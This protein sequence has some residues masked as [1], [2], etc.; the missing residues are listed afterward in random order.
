[1]IKPVKALSTDKTLSQPPPLNRMRAPYSWAWWVRKAPHVQVDP[2][3]IRRYQD[4]HGVDGY[5]VERFMDS[6]DEARP[7]CELY[8]G[9]GPH[10]QSMWIPATDLV[11]MKSALT[12]LQCRLT[13]VA[14]QEI[15]SRA[16]YRTLLAE[17]TEERAAIVQG[18]E[19]VQR[20]RTVAHMG[21]NLERA[22]LAAKAHAEK[23]K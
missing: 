10:A 23:A 12:H 8:P 15:A 13:E 20:R 2:V 14:L 3:R 18:V 16:R 4:S 17:L 5:Q 22:R 19:L 21:G 7:F 9:Q 1:M 11:D 6:V